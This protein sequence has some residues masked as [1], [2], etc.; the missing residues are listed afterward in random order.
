MYL[1]SNNLQMLISHKPK[2]KNEE[3]QSDYYAQLGI[4]RYGKL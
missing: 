1:A 4:I 3:L 2:Q